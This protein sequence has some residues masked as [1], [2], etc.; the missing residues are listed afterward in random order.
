VG[1]PLGGALGILVVGA[2]GN[3]IDLTASSSYYTNII[4][5]ILL[6]SAV[7]LD[8]LRGGDSYD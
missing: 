5:G 1:N 3:V 7:Y 8:R 4:V 6:L 2:L